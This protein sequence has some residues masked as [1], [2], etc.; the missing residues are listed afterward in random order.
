MSSSSY[1]QYSCCCCCCLAVGTPRG[2]PWTA[3]C[4]DSTLCSLNTNLAITKKYKYFFLCKLLYFFFFLDFTFAKII[5]LRPY[6]K[7]FKEKISKYVEKP[8]KCVR[9]IP[10]NLHGNPPKFAWKSAKMYEM[11]P[12]LASSFLLAAVIGGRRVQF[13]P[14]QYKCAAT[15]ILIY[16]CCHQHPLQ[17]FKIYIS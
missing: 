9:K 17:S 6:N 5:I 14:G 10:D 12:E 13:R 1:S 7:I 16:K 11:L 15:R 8:Q 3:W 2:S 4:S